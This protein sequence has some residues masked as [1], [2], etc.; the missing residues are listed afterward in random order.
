MQVY[1]SV[2]NLDPRFLFS[3]SL[4]WVIIAKKNAYTHTGYGEVPH[5]ST[6]RESWFFLEILANTV[7]HYHYFSA[8]L[9]SV[10]I[11]YPK[12]EVPQAT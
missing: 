5:V 12:S 8:L 6:G 2:Q 10:N 7:F 4:R 9:N 11:D 1:F 3:A